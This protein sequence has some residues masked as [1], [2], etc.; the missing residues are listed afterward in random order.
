[1]PRIHYFQRYSGPENSVTNN[2]LQLFS[3]IYEHS[4]DKFAQF[5]MDLLNLRDFS[6][7]VEF[8]QQK[9]GRSSIPDGFILQRSFKLLLE[10]KVQATVD[11]RQL[12]N[13]C[14]SFLGEVTKILV[15]LTVKPIER[16]LCDEI[17]R[18][19]NHKVSGV[20]FANITYNQIC[21]TCDKLFE[22]FED[23]I[24]AI[25]EDY[26][27]YCTETSLISDADDWMR[28][29]PTGKSF[30]L[31]KKYAMYFDPAD[32][33]YSPHAFIGFYTNKCVS[34]MI[35]IR[36]IFEVELKDGK[37]TKTL[38]SGEHTDEFDARIIAMIAEARDICHYEVASGHKFFCGNEAFDTEYRKSSRGGIMGARFANL[39]TLGI[40][41]FSN[42]AGVA[43]LLRTKTWQ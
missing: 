31:N 29:V 17:I 1:M 9:R 24:L 20:Q 2:T 33:G 19:I 12:V 42:V 23:Q 35:K 34:S 5:L 43:D 11:V 36:S 32:R 15:L 22:S 7:G 8:M 21:E 4:P 41:D 27:R 10:A 14:D 13:H 39:R 28:I 16:G 38:V 3:R 30:T 18:E 6:V 40:T 37:L 25:V 26:T